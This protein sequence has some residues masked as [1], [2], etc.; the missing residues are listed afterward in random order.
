M[1]KRKPIPIPN[2]SQEMQLELG[3]P[4]QSK[5]LKKVNR[6]KWA[7]PRFAIAKN[8]KI[9]RFSTTDFT[10]SLIKELNASH[11]LLFQ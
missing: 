6:S 4:V 10:E 9:I 8:D 5:V 3:L 7:T 11:I 1:L 2:K